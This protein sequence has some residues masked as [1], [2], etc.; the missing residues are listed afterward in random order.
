ML[1]GNM[2]LKAI[3]FCHLLCASEVSIKVGSDNK[4]IYR[5]RRA[6][7]EYHEYS[8][9]PSHVYCLRIPSQEIIW[10]DLIEMI[11]SK[12]VAKVT[13]ISTTACDIFLA[14]DQ[15]REVLVDNGRV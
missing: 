8:A 1:K 5:Q 2:L 10:A 15:L 7:I 3:E 14:E 11:H 4:K 6:T 9:K 13:L 12:G